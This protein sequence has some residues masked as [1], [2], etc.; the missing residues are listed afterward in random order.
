[1]FNDLASLT[2]LHIGERY[3][4]IVD[5]IQQIQDNTLAWMSLDTI[6]STNL[7][8]VKEELTLALQECN[9]NVD[10]ELP[11]YDLKCLTRFPGYFSNF[12]ELKFERHD[13]YHTQVWKDFF[14]NPPQPEEE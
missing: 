10:Y 5:E 2:Q 14:E 6:T 12:R 9:L 1:M 11:Y 13:S 7:K 4:K 8:F 3:R